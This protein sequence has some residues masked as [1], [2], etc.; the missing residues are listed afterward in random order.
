[1]PFSKYLMAFRRLDAST[2]Q[3]GGNQSV[4]QFFIFPTCHC[5]AIDLPF[6]HYYSINLKSLLLN[7][8]DR[9]RPQE[10]LITLLKVIISDLSKGYSSEYETVR[11]WLTV[12][13][14][15]TRLEHNPPTGWTDFPIRTD[16]KNKQL[17][18]GSWF[19][20]IAIKYLQNE[21]P[22][23]YWWWR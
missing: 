15:M 2:A 5:A 10:L 3:T 20:L 8:R 21:S 14:A 22:V 16:C 7:L 18:V 17:R 6:S 11:H 13:G 19:F 9:N 23:V 4:S 12:R 1:M